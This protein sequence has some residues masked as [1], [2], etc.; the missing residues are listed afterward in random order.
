MAKQTPILIA[1][2][3][4]F[5]A[6]NGELIHNTQSRYAEYREETNPEHKRAIKEKFNIKLTF[7]DESLKLV[8][9]SI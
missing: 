6:L 1:E 3:D 4:N 8:P 9:P 5:A 2:K 7:T